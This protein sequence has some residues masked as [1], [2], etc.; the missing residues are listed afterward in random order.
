MRSRADPLLSSMNAEGLLQAD[1]LGLGIAV[2]RLGH[3][4]GYQ[5]APNPNLFVAGP[6]ARGTFGE[7]MGISDLA[8]YAEKIAERIA[9]SYVADNYRTPECAR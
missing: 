5:N 2:D 6:L 9:A 1:T 7:L 3:A 4:I 8:T